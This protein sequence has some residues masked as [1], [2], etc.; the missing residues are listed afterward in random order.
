[1]GGKFCVRGKG[2]MS[3]CYNSHCKVGPTRATFT[4]VTKRLLT[5]GNCAV[6]CKKKDINL[7]NVTTSTT[8]TTNKGIM[9]VVP[10]MFVTTRRT[11]HLV[12]RLVRIPSLVTEGQGVVRTNSTFLVLPKKFK[13]LRRFTSATIRCRVCARRAGHPPVVVTGVRKVCSPL[14]TLFRG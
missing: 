6:V 9:K 13:A 3:I 4:K 7:V 2:G 14:H 12:A 10:R 11:R 5:G 1:M 8:L